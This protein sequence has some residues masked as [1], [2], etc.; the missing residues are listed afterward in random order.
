MTGLQ[1]SLFCDLVAEAT[2]VRRERKIG[3]AARPGTGPKGQRCNTCSHCMLVECRGVVSRKCQI[4]ARHWTPSSATDIKHNAPACSE[5]E[6][7][8]Y[9]AK[10]AEVVRYTKGKNPLESD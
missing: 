3:Y 5:W 9:T 8:P 4:M 1:L 2:A 7:K 10:P 6:R